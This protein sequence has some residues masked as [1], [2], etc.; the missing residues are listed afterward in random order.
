MCKIIF[1]SL[2]NFTHITQWVQ[3]VSN[4]NVVAHRSQIVCI[5]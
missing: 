2:L 3:F 5:Q 1:Q 4:P